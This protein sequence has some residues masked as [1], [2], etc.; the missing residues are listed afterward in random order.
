MSPFQEIAAAFEKETGI[1][2]DVSFTS[3]GRI[4]AQIENGAPYDIFLSADVERPGPALWKI[5]VRK[6]VCLVLKAK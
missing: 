6:T 5:P 4:Y 1:S 3:A 2:I